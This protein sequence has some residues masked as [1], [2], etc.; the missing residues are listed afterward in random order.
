M[1]TLPDITYIIIRHKNY[2]KKLNSFSIYSKEYLTLIQLI[3]SINFEK[4]FPLNEEFILFSS[5]NNLTE[6]WK[7]IE[8]IFIKCKSLDFS[9]NSNILFNSKFNI[10]F[11]SIINKG[12][13]YKSEIQ[14]WE[15]ENKLP[16]TK[17]KSFYMDF[18]KE[19]E[20]FF[21]NN[22][23][24]IVI[25]NCIVDFDAYSQH[26]NNSGI[27]FY[28]M[29]NME[30]VKNFEL[31]NKYCDLK[32]IKLDENRI[33]IIEKISDDCSYD[34][35][36]KQN[37]RI[38]VIPEFKVVKEFEPDFPI[39]DVLIHKNYFIFYE[40]MIKV[41]NSQNY[42][43]IKEIYIK[44]IHSLINLKDNYLIGLVNQYITDKN[45]FSLEKKNQIRDLV[46]YEIN[47]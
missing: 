9:I 12:N 24:K 18:S 32:P 17:L 28:K 3:S 31:D 11:H 10:F 46:I 19:K 22:E 42:Q 33:I 26:E 15:T 13:E 6:I 5:K 36:I 20:I 2:E 23:K 38:M 37:V 34:E 29:Y 8:N 43:L 25:Y 14:I 27:A 45:D 44:G 7:K 16:I 30:N 41:Y 39:T 21:M 1:I 35:D 47:I 40:S 4:C